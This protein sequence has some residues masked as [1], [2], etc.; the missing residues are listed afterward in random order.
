MTKPGHMP[1]LDGLR[2]LAALLV[3]TGHAPEFGLLS[4]VQPAAKDYGVLIFFS[5]SGFLM[6]SLYLSRGPT[7]PAIA[8]YLASRIARI[9]PIYFAVVLASYAYAHLV[10]SSFVYAMPFVQ[11]L[12]QLTFNGSISVFWSIGPEFQFYFLF[13]PL[14]L[15]SFRR[16]RIP[17]AMS[18]ALLSLASLAMAAHVPGVLIASKFHIFAC[19]LAAAEIRLN[20][21][22]LPARFT[23]VVH[24]LC[25]I[26]VIMIMVS[27]G[28]AHWIGDDRINIHIDPTL[29]EFFANPAR[30]VLA[31]CIVLGLSYPGAPG[32]WVLGSA[33]LRLLGAISFSVYLLH[34][35]IYD[36]MTKAGLLGGFG[37]GWGAAWAM[38]AILAVSWVSYQLIERPA[39]QWLATRLQPAPEMIT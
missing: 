23:P 9:V 2:G 39:R 20:V 28:F 27:P 22:N 25:L 3:V 35:A 8:S 38:T 4:P 21:P 30:V 11:L 17:Y 10:D 26:A 5:L 33:P 18:L 29:A 6:G 16:N 37:P 14:W 1:A 34:V 13:V 15:L 32:H 7:R 31:S 24:A 12:R 19:G 36:L